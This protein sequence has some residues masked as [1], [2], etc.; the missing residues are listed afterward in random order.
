M[1]SSIVSQ[2]FA[3]WNQYPHRGDVKFYERLE[4]QI[5]SREDRSPSAVMA[6]SFELV[7]R[8]PL[9]GYDVTELDRWT[10]SDG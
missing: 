1:R 5:R 2:H 9:F 3:S 10:A 4:A 8:E 6:Q 7:D